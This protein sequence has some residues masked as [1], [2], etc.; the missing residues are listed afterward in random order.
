MMT[1]KETLR[2]IRGD[3]PKLRWKNFYRYFFLNA[4]FRLLL[5]YR[6]GK[7]FFFKKNRL[8]TLIA[9]YIKYKMISKRGADISF[10][11][12]IGKN[13]R[14]PHPIGIV[15][16]DG[17]VIH[18]NVKIWHGVTLGSHG[19]K[20]YELSYPTIH[21]GVRIYA[22]AKIIGG[23]TIG[24]DAIIGAN[25]VVNIDVPAGATAVGIPCKIIIK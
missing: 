13:L 5:S 24:R 16:G 1:L 22:G 6:L 11:A 23:I 10:H 12:T 18:D 17:V 25:S 14:L 19:K 8:A 9:K 21:E 7:Y 20:G 4:A 15:V 2:E 3:A